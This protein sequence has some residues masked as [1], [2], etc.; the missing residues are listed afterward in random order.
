VKLLERFRGAAAKDFAEPVECRAHFAALVNATDG[1]F[2]PID[3][4]PVFVRPRGQGVR[5]AD[6]L[7]E[8]RACSEPKHD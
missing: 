7:I 6:A 4:N 8:M 3:L 1:L 5:I 2:A